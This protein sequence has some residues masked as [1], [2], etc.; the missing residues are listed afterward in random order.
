[1]GGIVTSV[2]GTVEAQH[3]VAQCYLCQRGKSCKLYVLRRKGETYFRR[4]APDF[5]T[6]FQSF[7]QVGDFI[8]FDICIVIDKE[9]VFAFCCT[10]A[11]VVTTGKTSVLIA[12]DT[13]NRWV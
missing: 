6:T 1:M 10:D 4:H 3:I 12:A 11:N 2:I 8:G 9:N 7:H 13:D 5:R